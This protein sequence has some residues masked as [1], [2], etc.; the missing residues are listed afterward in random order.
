MNILTKRDFVRTS[1]SV[2][3][4][5]L[6]HALR[7][8]YLANA[9]PLAPAPVDSLEDKIAALESRNTPSLSS[10]M[11]VWN[12]SGES[13]FNRLVIEQSRFEASRMPPMGGIPTPRPAP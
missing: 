13:G 8:S 12:R 6:Q 1:A 3:T 9:A 10:S 5:G 4:I 2:K 11:S 7:S